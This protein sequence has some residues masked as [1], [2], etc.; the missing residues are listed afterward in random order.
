MYVNGKHSLMGPSKLWNLG[1]SVSLRK[2][3][4][5]PGLFTVALP[6]CGRPYCG[7]WALGHLLLSRAPGVKPSQRCP[8]VTRCC[9]QRWVIRKQD[10]DSGIYPGT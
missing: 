1:E 10:F 6:V 7:A 2:H 4:A 5:K 9:W 3:R 8:G